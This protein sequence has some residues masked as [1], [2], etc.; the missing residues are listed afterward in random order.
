MKET[1]DPTTI[2]SHILL[3]QFIILFCVRGR[4]AKTVISSVFCMS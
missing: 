1:K 4:S 2:W 3:S